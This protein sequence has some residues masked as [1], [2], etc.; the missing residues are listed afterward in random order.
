MIR[1]GVIGAGGIG[2]AN[3]KHLSVHSK[4]SLQPSVTP[5]KRYPRHSLLRTELNL[6]P[7]HID[8]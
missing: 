8:D 1:A 6:T 3:L 7:I 4:S 2:A 5:M